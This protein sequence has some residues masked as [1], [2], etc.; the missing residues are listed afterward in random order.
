MKRQLTA[1]QA[2]ARDARREKFKVLW[3]QVSKMS[4]DQKRAMLD[5]AGV[6]FTTCEGH[7]LSLNN[8]LLICLQ[9]P[10]ASVL[11]GF[12]QWIRAGRC[13]RKGQHGAMIWVPTGRKAQAESEP[14]EPPAVDPAANGD[15]EA[16]R[17][18]FIMGTVFDI[19]QTAE[20]GAVEPEPIPQPTIEP[21][22]AAA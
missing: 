12:K 2:A 7:A 22:L 10:G 21:A 9:I 4:D 15:T 14:T 1:E 17:Q 20:L 13:V 3:R 18:G 16:R 5:G 11:G 6:I 19:S 8:C